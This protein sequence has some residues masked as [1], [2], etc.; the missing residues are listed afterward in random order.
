M[1]AYTQIGMSSNST[2]KNNML[3]KPY[4]CIKYGF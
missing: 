2:Y 3:P 1:H 4:Q